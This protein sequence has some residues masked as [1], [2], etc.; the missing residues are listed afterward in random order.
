MDFD[1]YRYYTCE[2][3]WQGWKCEQMGFY[4]QFDYPAKKMSADALASKLILVSQSTPK[5]FD[6]LILRMKLTFPVTIEK[7]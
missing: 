2:L 3:K 5:T 1:K 6:N 4:D 7:Y